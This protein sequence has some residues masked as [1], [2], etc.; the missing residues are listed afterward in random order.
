MSPL[1]TLNATVEGNK[2]IVDGTVSDGNPYPFFPN[3]DLVQDE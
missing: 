1:D 3:Q 2:L